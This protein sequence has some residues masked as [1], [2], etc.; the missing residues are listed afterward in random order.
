M[1]KIVAGNAVGQMII[2]A[3]AKAKFTRVKLSRLSGISCPT[4]TAY[5]CMDKGQRPSILRKLAVAMDLSPTTF[6]DPAIASEIETAYML[7]QCGFIEENRQPEGI[8]TFVREPMKVTITSEGVT[9][10]FHSAVDSK[11]MLLTGK[12]SLR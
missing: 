10:E 9:M 5:E 12:T 6:I 11:T 1:K 7:L 3:R 8:R 2:D 4:I